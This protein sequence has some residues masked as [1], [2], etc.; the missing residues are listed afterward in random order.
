M[1]AQTI[2]HIMTGLILAGLVLISIGIYLIIFT[3]IAISNGTSGIFSIAGLIAGGLFISVPA[4]I[5]L[6]LLL[7]KH[8]DEMLKARNQA[9]NPTN[10]HQE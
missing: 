5:Y 1:N 7:M 6:T 8:N 9:N 4:K 10:P 2:K 3:D